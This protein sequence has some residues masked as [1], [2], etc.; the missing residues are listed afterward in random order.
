MDEFKPIAGFSKYEMS[1]SMV[2]N[3]STKT[4]IKKQ[5]DGTFYLVDD[6][7]ESQYIKPMATKPVEE[8]VIEEAEVVNE[9]ETVGDV[10]I[11]EAKPEKA[12][13]EKPAKEVKEKKEKA[14]KSEKKEKVAKP[15]SDKIEY[16]KGDKVKFIDVKTK[17]EHTGTVVRARLYKGAPFLELEAK[18]FDKIIYRYQEKVTRA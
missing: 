4:A 10:K 13:K 6:A 17:K 5:K 12:K 7:G 9:P 8:E 15:G 3:R 1:G 14:T 18:G 16:S 11:E 2:R